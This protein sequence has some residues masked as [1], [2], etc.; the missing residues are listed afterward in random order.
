MAQ[1]RIEEAAEAYGLHS[2]MLTA[3]GSADYQLDKQVGV[4]VP[5]QA[6]LPQLVQASASDDQRRVQLETVCAE[7]WVLEEFHEGLDVA[8]PAHIG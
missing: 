8:L 3:A 4:V 2:C 7:G 6:S 5:I 1:T